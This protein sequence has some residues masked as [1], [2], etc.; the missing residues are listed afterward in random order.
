VRAARAVLVASLL[1]LAVPASAEPPPERDWTFDVIPYVW[2]PAMTGDVTVRGRKADVDVSIGDLFTE[3]DFIFALQAQLEAWY[4]QRFGFVFN[5]QW[6]WL[7][8]DDN[9]FGPAQGPPFGPG[10][11]P[12]Q[13]DLRTNL[14]LFEILGAYRVGTWELGSGP[15]PP[16]LT[17]E[18]IVGARIT[19]LKVTFDPKGGS[20]LD[21]SRTWVD[22]ILGARMTLALGEERRWHLRIRGDF[23]GFGAGTD[24]TW[25]VVGALGYEWRFET[26]QVEAFLGVRA[27]DQ[28]YGQG[29]GTGRFEWDV[30]QYGPVLGL[31]F[32]F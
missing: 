16:A 18:P 19:T 3:T 12:I 29:S 17:L 14:G 28:D 6:T 24:F 26:C 7:D 25:N 30:T 32:H 31:A 4:R 23:G 10:V 22:P 20:D 1:L 13:F 2:L 8:Q 27:L 15:S 5:G 9:S 21:Q 11:F